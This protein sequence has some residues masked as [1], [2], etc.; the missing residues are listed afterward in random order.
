MSAHTPEQTADPDDL[1]AEG[2]AADTSG[3]DFE[4]FDGRMVSTPP[5]W[6]YRALID[7]AAGPD[8]ATLLDLGTGG[9]EWLAGW[10]DGRTT[11]LPRVVAAESWPPNV[12]V[13]GRR[14]APLGVTVVHTDGAL[15]NVDQGP[16]DRSG[17]LP[18]RGASFD[19][20]VNR[21]S[22]YRPEEV[23]RVLRPGGTFV[24][25]QVAAGDGTLHRLLDLPVPP[26]G[27]WTL[28]YAVNQAAEGGLTVVDAGV[29]ADVT[30]YHD[31]APLAWYLRQVPWAVPGYDPVRDPDRLRRVQ[32][33]IDTHGPL[34]IR[35]HHFWL[36]AIRRTD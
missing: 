36:R 24:T 17:R 33:Y 13:A 16:A 32:R 29:G 3:W 35:R 1:I 10:L 28:R 4:R 23:A 20:V 6:D 31:V 34:E 25:Q 21:H 27:D 14:L 2:L 12:P 19:A 9:G 15:D 11:A 7:A 18:F 22:S 5:P 8:T 30:T 26:A